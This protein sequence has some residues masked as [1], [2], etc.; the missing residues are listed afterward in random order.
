MAQHMKGPWKVGHEAL[1]VLAPHPQGGYV[2][3]YAKVCDIRGWGFLTGKGALGLPEEEA[4]AIQEAN[5]RLIA[6]APEM[7]EATYNALECLMGCVKPAGGC[8][9]DAVIQMTIGMLK[10]A[11][12]KAEGR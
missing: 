2:G 5:A 9:D 11:I 12:A 8:D 7:L 3:G 1:D 10:A 4:R 6:A